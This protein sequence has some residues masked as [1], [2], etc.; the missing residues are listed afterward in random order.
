LRIKQ[1]LFAV[2]FVFLTA[3]GVLSITGGKIREALLLIVPASLHA[4]LADIEKI[5]QIC[6]DEFLL[7]YEIPQPERAS[8]SLHEYPVTLIGTNSFY[9]RLLGLSMTTGSFFTKQA[10]DGKQRH[11]VLNEEAAFTIFGSTHISGQRLKMNGFFWIVT[12]VVED[13]DG[14][15]CRV[16]VPSSLKGVPAASLLALA[17]GGGKIN[18]VYVKDILKTLGV[19]RDT[20]TFFNLE[21]HARLPREQ[22]VVALYSFCCALLIILF[23][24]ELERCKAAFFII[25]E[26]LKSRYL[27]ELIKRQTCELLRILAPVLI[28]PVCGGLL[29]FLLLRIFA[30][31]LPWQDLISL[32]DLDRN[33][34]YRTI[35]RLRNYET[36]SWVLCGASVISSAAACILNVIPARK[37]SYSKGQSKN[38]PGP[39]SYP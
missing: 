13:G 31:C 39:R 1:L 6:E 25:R 17:E 10:W 19:N 29:I 5:E 2:P 32:K 36:A 24:R 8:A 15:T 20:F 16:Y 28:L 35:S 9:P 30:A 3:L 18:E 22:A 26:E 11:A 12:G 34:F 4:P 37:N 21:A 14:E 27:K 7:T 33:I 38:L 23:F